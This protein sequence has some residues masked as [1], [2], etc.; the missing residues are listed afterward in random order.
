MEE[1]RLA[2]NEIGLWKSISVEPDIILHILRYLTT[3]DIINMEEASKILEDI[4]FKV[5]IWKKKISKDFKDFQIDTVETK[6]PYKE[7]YWELKYLGHYCTGNSKCYNVC[8]V[9]RKTT[10]CFNIS[11]CRHCRYALL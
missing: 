1:G 10:H 7:I 8:N 6:T 2:E 5:N 4:V 11:K 3:K 9:C